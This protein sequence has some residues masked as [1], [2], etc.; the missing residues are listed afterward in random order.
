MPRWYIPSDGHER[1]RIDR[2]RAELSGD[3]LDAFLRRVPA[4]PSSAPVESERPAPRSELCV[5]ASELCVDTDVDLSAIGRTTSTLEEGAGII[6]A[7]SQLDADLLRPVL[8]RNFGK[9]S[10]VVV[11]HRYQSKDA[12]LLER[13]K[14]QDEPEPDVASSECARINL[15]E[16]DFEGEI[17][18]RLSDIFYRVI[19]DPAVQQK[20]H[21]VVGLSSF[22]NSSL[23]GVATA[24]AQCDLP[25][26]CSRRELAIGFRRTVAEAMTSLRCADVYHWSATILF[27]SYRGC[28]PLDTTFFEESIADFGLQS[29]VRQC[30]HVEGENHIRIE[31]RAVVN[32]TE[33]R[34]VPD[35]T[36]EEE[37]M[38]F[39]F[40]DF[41]RRDDNNGNS[42]KG[43]VAGRLVGGAPEN[44]EM[45]DDIDVFQLRS[46]Y[47]NIGQ[48]FTLVDIV[49][50]RAAGG[51][52]STL[53]GMNLGTRK[54][55]HVTLPNYVERLPSERVQE[56]QEQRARIAREKQKAA[57]LK[58]ARLAWKLSKNIKQGQSEHTLYRDEI[59]EFGL[60]KRDWACDFEPEEM[61]Y[62]DP[63]Y[64][65][66]AEGPGLMF[67]V[68]KDMI[69]VLKQR[70]ANVKYVGKT[71]D[72]PYFR[73]SADQREPWIDMSMDKLRTQWL[74]TLI[75][76]HAEKEQVLSSALPPPT[77]R[78]SFTP[79]AFPHYDTKPL[80]GI[81]CDGECDSQLAT[82]F[83]MAGFTVRLVDN[84]DEDLSNY[85]G[86]AFLGA[87]PS[88]GAL[89][90][91]RVWAARARTSTS[92]MSFFA[93]TDT[94]SLGIGTGCLM[95]SAL[96]PF[97]SDAGS[98]VR[99][100]RNRSNRV[101]YRKHAQVVIA[102]SPAQQVWFAGMVGS[103]MPCTVAHAFGRY[104]GSSD[105]S[106]LT[107]VDATG[108]AAVGFPENPF[109]TP[110][111]QA[112]IVSADGRHLGL[113]VHPERFLK[114][115]DYSH[116]PTNWAPGW[117]P[118]LQMFHNVRAWCD[119]PDGPRVVTQTA[120]TTA[121]AE[122]QDPSAEETYQKCDVETEEDTDEDTDED[123]YEDIDEDIDHENIGKLFEKNDEKH[124]DDD[125]NHVDN[126]GTMAEDTGSDTNKKPIDE[127][128]GKDNTDTVNASTVSTDATP[129]SQNSSSPA[130]TIERTTV[131]L[132]GP[133][134]VFFHKRARDDGA[135]VIF[136]K[137]GGQDT[138]G[139]KQA[140]SKRPCTVGTPVATTTEA[141]A[142]P[143]ITGPLS[144]FFRR[145]PLN[146]TNSTQDD[147]NASK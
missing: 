116:R 132:K 22:G 29:R 52:V 139:T 20:T 144:A 16:P 104:V 105:C 45:M 11:W 121:A 21:Q 134:A 98:D 87:A 115:D 4:D 81:V 72:E 145:R 15:R 51:L 92:L 17:L 41:L 71:I 46:A 124:D 8:E 62:M 82:A 10:Q 65:L 109:G 47:A 3:F 30:E 34:S 143:T 14:Y 84:F 96:W 5:E 74:R 66:F 53:V 57:K 67:A 79:K 55:I 61:P 138:R 38:H 60:L 99:F 129:S 126:V 135:A 94:F 108:H 13:I 106:P 44:D 58:L 78:V 136:P 103:E 77:Y 43:T 1:L 23:N 68:T 90:P 89:S 130:T 114:E 32:D 24:E 85:Q 27:W 35:V 137:H 49:R 37:E 133:L 122:D 102:S 19:R 42:L 93:R 12:S 95:L 107:F 39:V 33:N 112:G 75:D 101:A 86:L 91:G 140:P 142:G 128:K 40:V 120:T 63:L 36:E 7:D 56:L 146:S 88:D 131:P 97:A 80:V 9:V 83:E 6:E 70:L 18:N 54:G 28:V 127:V 26:D 31:A 147:D 50:P 118:W 48:I 64:N 73:V 110:L 100:T 2:G 117:A 25:L 111:G 113:M 125:I 119:T 76:A 123:T 69:P 141:P 59:A